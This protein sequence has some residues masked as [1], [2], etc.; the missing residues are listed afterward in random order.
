MLMQNFM[1]LAQKIMIHVSSV[2]S[3][4]YIAQISH[5]DIL[6]CLDSLKEVLGDEIQ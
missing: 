2:F 4:L 6:I 3:I 1:Q 5:H